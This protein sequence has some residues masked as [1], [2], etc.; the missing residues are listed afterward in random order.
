M[1]QERLFLLD[2]T[3]LAYRSHF[4]FA[5]SGLTAVDGRPT[6]A[7]FGY[8]MVLRR[9]LERHPRPTL[10]LLTGLMLGSTRALWPW[11]GQYD[12]KAGEL[13]NHFGL[14]D[15]GALALCG[16]VLAALAGG[17]AVLLL[18]WVERRAAAGADAG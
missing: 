4:A 15:A 17:G 8:T 6:G 10:S 12:P 14:L 9:L 2:G 1:T 13:A 18:E 5:R 16:V 11:K 3:A 7:T